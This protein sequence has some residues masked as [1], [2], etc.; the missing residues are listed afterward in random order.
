MDRASRQVGVKIDEPGKKCGST[1]IDD[2]RTRR[3]RDVG[4]HRLD[5]LAAHH[6]DR[7]GKRYSAVSIDEPMR[8]DRDYPVR[9]S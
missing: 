6:D 5:A 8:A 4:S 9:W 3:D 7:G 2:G 1:E